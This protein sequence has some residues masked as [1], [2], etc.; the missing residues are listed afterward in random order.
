MHKILSVLTDLDIFSS[1]FESYSDN[2]DPDLSQ[3]SQKQIRIH[4]VKQPKKTKVN[5]PQMHDHKKIF[6]VKIS[7]L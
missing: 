1:S 2:E 3:N 7:K 4:L 6:P 5:L